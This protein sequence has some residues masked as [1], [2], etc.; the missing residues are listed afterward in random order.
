MDFDDLDMSNVMVQVMH[1][2]ILVEIGR[3]DVWVRLGWIVPF[4][5]IY[6]L[7]TSRE[8][9]SRRRQ[10]HFDWGHLNVVCLYVCMIV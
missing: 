8:R 1:D 7:V 9:K 2:D 10:L 5:L 4:K 6:R 3:W